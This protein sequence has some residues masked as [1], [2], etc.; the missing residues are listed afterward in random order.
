MNCKLEYFTLI[1]KQNGAKSLLF[2]TSYCY[3]KEFV[4]SVTDDVIIFDLVSFNSEMSTPQ[5]MTL[6]L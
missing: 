5:Y 6:D 2:N 4:T 3:K 1:M